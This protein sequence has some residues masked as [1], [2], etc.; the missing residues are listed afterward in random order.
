MRRKLAAFV[1]LALATIAFGPAGGLAQQATVRTLAPGIFVA[2][3]ISAAD[4]AMLK[5]GGVALVVDLLPDDEAAPQ[6]RSQQMEAA[7]RE[8][9]VD[10]VYAPTRSQ[11]ITPEAV[12][13]VGKALA[14]GK[15]PVLVYCR[16]G[17][18]ASRT[19]ALAE[20][21]RPDGMDSAGILRAVAGAGY[22]ADDLRGELDR[23]IGARA[24]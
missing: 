9:G 10:F 16:S 1:L 7:A 18:R 6:A 2:P 17:S 13:G 4:V 24:K 8:A 11:P 14:T 3:A 15:R 5:Q 19:W 22:S 12:A 23:R 20:A 21:S